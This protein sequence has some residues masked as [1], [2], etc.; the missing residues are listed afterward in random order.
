MLALRNRRE[1][2]GVSRRPMRRL[3]TVIL[4]AGVLALPAAAAPGAGPLLALQPQ[5]DSEL[6]SLVELDP[7]TLAPVGGSLA[8]REKSVASWSRSPDGLWL[9]LSPWDV[10]R[11]MIIDR[12]SMRLVGEVRVPPGSVTRG[13]DVVLHGRYAQELVWISP[14]RLLALVGSCCSAGMSVMVV[15]LES[16]RVVAERAVPGAVRVV[17]RLPD[18]LALVLGGARIGPGRVAVVGPDGR[19]RT[20]ALPRTRLGER[21]LPGDDYRVAVRTPA[22]AVDPEA[23]RAYV[24]GVDEPVAEVDLRT[25]RVTYHAPDRRRTLQVRTKNIRGSYRSAAW[26][27]EGVLALTGW[28]ARQGR[29]GGPRFEPAGVHLI[30]TRSWQRR[31]LAPRAQW[32]AVSGQTLVVQLAAGLAVFGPDGVERMRVPGR[33]GGV[34]AIDG[35]AYA[36]RDGVAI[37]VVDLETG[38]TSSVA[39][40]RPLTLLGP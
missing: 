35:R 23:R 39:V 27:G 29:R 34:Q 3:L 9:A 14:R 10:A 19:I 28:N 17:A 16:G 8:L 2:G 1:R 5:P 4:V 15:D 18:G 40:D 11:I 24:I 37:L 21:S 22:L 7:M 26:V 33:F 38:A 36:W 13:R 32:F 6:L 12:T 20:A 31:T 30:D 25:L